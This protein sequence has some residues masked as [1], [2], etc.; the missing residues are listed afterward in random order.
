MVPSD[1]D[2]S[3]DAVVVVEAPSA[4][5]APEAVDDE[6]EAVVEADDADALDA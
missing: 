5:S 4:S 6:V 2:V 1:V 3:L